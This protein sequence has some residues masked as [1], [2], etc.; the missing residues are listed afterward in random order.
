MI[1]D[2]EVNTTSYFI[3]RS[4][5]P[6]KEMLLALTVRAQASTWN[7]AAPMPKTLGGSSVGLGDV[8]SLL[9]YVASGARASRWSLLTVPLLRLALSSSLCLPFPRH[10]ACL[11][12]VLTLFLAL[13]LV[14][15]PRSHLCFPVPVHVAFV[16]CR[17]CCTGVTGFQVV[18]P[19]RP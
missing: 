4:T 5:Q 11:V 6:A 8:P 15:D 18:C 13:I 2:L 10:S 19:F 1:F 9:F 14:P 17:V 12:L 3:W 7:K 16:I